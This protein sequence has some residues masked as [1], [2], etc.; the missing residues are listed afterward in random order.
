MLTPNISVNN[1]RNI[2]LSE[3]SIE[4][5]ITKFMVEIRLT[6]TAINLHMKLISLNPSLV[7]LWLETL[8]KTRNKTKTIKRAEKMR[9]IWS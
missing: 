8:P 1:N 9:I 3:I 4:T 2:F 6:L 7:S 5:S